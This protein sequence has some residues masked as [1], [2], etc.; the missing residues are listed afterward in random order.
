MPQAWGGGYENIAS[1]ETSTVGGGYSNIASGYGATVSGGYFNLAGGD[2]SWAG[3]NEARVRDAA[4]VGG[5][6]TTGDQGT[7]VWSDSQGPPFQSTGQNQFLVRAAGGVGIN[8]NNPAA[9]LDINGNA[10][11]SGNLGIGTIAPNRSLHI[12]HNGGVEMSMLVNDGLTDW[13]T[14]NIWTSGGAGVKQN[15]NFRL[16]NDLGTATTL[17]VFHLNSDGSAWLNGTLASGGLASTLAGGIAVNGSST[18][19]YGVQGTSTNSVG[20]VGVSTNNTG[21]WGQ[22]NTGTAVDG[23]STSGVGVL[24]R[25]TSGNGVK[26]TTGNTIAI[27]AVNNSTDAPAI[28]GWNQG[29]GYLYRG[30]SG[31]SPV[32]KFWV[33]NNGN[34]W[35]A[36]TLTQAS[37]ARLKTDIRPL[38]DTLD[39]VLRLR[40]VSYVMK[41]D[42]TKTRR[43]G[44]I[45]QELEREYPELVATDDQGMKSVAYA[46][47]T[48]V[49]IEAVKQLKAENDALK[50]RLDRIEQLLTTK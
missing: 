29:S 36:G 12:A 28:E 24:G 46:N 20:V 40:G 13:R 15:L 2:Y 8:K 5:G 41:S 43:I 48:A 35:L 21:V 14:W 30:W 6:N 38:E 25:S 10:L 45:A 39:K 16:L 17:D 3:G 18:S 47:L 44:V 31:A 4:T 42:E 50:A 33:A 9:A 49:L 7:F 34:A 11:V 27:Y 23:S 26:G 37:D 1:G 32:L 22:A 19:S